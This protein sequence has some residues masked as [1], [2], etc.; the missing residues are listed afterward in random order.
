MLKQLSKLFSDIQD[1]SSKSEQ[2]DESEQRIAC[3]AL[4]IHS[5]RVDGNF[6]ISELDVLKNILSAKFELSDEEVDELIEA[7]DDK[8]Q[9]SVDLYSFTK[10]LASNLDQEGRKEIIS[11]LWQIILA[12]NKIDDYEDHLIRNISD[13]LGVSTRDRVTSKQEVITRQNQDNK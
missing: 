12:D 3:A 13:L 9:K 1:N 4:L 2:M 11:M 7:A 8:E 6:E 5:A 10:V